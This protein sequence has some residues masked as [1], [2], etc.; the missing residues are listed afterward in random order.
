M[1]KYYK[2]YVYTYKYYKELCKEKFLFFLFFEAK[3]D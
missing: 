2:E 3:F 1:Y